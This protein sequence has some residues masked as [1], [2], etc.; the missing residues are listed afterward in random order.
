MVKPLANNVEEA[1][2]GPAVTIK[3]PAMEEEA[4]AAKPPKASSVKSG[5][6]EPGPNRIKAG[7]VVAKPPAAAVVVAKVRKVSK[8]AEVEVAVM[9][10]TD[11]AS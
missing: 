7:A 10:T 8:L 9:V 4:L 5:E 6:V 2:I 1:W 11:L 3:V